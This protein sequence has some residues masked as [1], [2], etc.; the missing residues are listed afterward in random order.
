MWLQDKAHVSAGCG[1]KS[2][3]SQNQCPTNFNKL[4]LTEKDGPII[5]TSCSVIFKPLGS[6]SASR[7][8]LLS[9]I[10][11]EN[12]DGALQGINVDLEFLDDVS[13]FGCDNDNVWDHSGNE[14]SSDKEDNGKTRTDND[15]DDP[16]RR[17]AG[18]H[19]PGWTF[20][21]KRCE[22][23]QLEMV[24]PHSL[25]TSHLG[26][27]SLSKEVEAKHLLYE[28]DLEDSEDYDKNEGEDDENE[29]QYEEENEFLDANQIEVGSNLVGSSSLC[30]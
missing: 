18:E 20:T 16:R 8:K 1:I 4:W 25:L 27:L 13:I 14:F 17:T 29:F 30:K 15:L 22:E 24:T 23:R 9:P 6:L 10:E 21:T 7:P 11:L 19:Q 12:D 26:K 3:A 2:A 5:H 28:F